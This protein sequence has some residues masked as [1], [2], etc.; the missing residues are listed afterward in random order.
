MCVHIVFLDKL[1]ELCVYLSFQL[2]CF[3][4]VTLRE[5]TCGETLIPFGNRFVRLFRAVISKKQWNFWCHSLF[6][7]FESTKH[8]NKLFT[9]WL[10]HPLSKLTLILTDYFPLEE[11]PF[12]EL[13]FMKFFADL[14]VWPRDTPR[15]TSCMSF[16][17]QVI[18]ELN[19]KLVLK[20]YIIL[21]KKFIKFYQK[22]EV[23]DFNFIL[24]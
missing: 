5:K 15:N 16:P 2:S 11:K 1:A 9:L 4:Y 6:L 20:W 23:Y 24:K 10:F 21:I 17:G 7:I 22:S 13:V 3:L 8:V 12:F 14:N 18:F 19:I